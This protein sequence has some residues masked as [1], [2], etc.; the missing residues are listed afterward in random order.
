MYALDAFANEIRT[1]R[2]PPYA[3][4]GSGEA[5]ADADGTEIAAWMGHPYHYALSIG[6]GMALE[7]VE[8][9]A[10]RRKYH[11][12]VEYLDGLQWDGTARLDH[13]LSDFFGCTHDEYTAAV[14]RS[15]LMSAVARVRSPGCKV[16]FMVI[17][18]GKQGRGNVHG[19]AHALRAAV[20]RGDDAIAPGQ[21]L[22][23]D[24][25]RALDHRDS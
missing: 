24:T 22:L 21:G 8:A 16:D 11:P 1:T 18:E 9:V 4:S 12:V 3:G 17:L 6:S 15:W 14:G 23:P 7:A 25:L 20:V 2:A 13:M 5:L 19:R 10:R